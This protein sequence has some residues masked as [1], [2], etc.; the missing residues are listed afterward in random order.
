MRRGRRQSL[1]FCKH[2]EERGTLVLTACLLPLLI[3]GYYLLLTTHCLLLTT[4]TWRIMNMQSEVTPDRNWRLTADELPRSVRS[5]STM[6]LTCEGVGVRWV[7]WRWG[8]VR[9]RLG[10]S[11]CCRAERETRATSL[12][13]RY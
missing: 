6:R 5:C 3:T 13:G 1:T 4:Y 10:E 11:S 2:R 8:G 7:G 12:R 9:V